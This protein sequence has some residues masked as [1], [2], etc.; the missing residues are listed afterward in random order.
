[1][2]TAKLRQLAW[3]WGLSLV[4]SALLA[5]AGR[6]WSDPPP[7]RAGPVLAL[8]VLPPLLMLAVLVRNWRL[9]AAGQEGES[10]GGAQ[11]RQ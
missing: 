4:L 7:V 5:L 10:V 9:P 8:L 11:E 2:S 1:M 6:H 3:V